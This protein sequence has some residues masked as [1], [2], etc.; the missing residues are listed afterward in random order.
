MKETKSEH[1]LAMREFDFQIR[2]NR[3]LIYI[4]THEESRVMDA[5]KKICLRSDHKNWELFSWDISGGLCSENKTKTLPANANILDQTEILNWF[6]NEDPKQENGFQILIL[7]DFGKLIGSDGNPGQIEYQIIRELR[8]QSHINITK[9]K[10]IVILGT[11]LFLPPELEKLTTVIDWPLPEKIDIKEKIEELIEHAKTYDELKSKFKLEY[12]EAELDEIITAFQGLTLIEVELLCSYMILTEPKFDSSLISSKKRDIVR[13]SGLID[14]VEVENG[15]DS[16]GGLYELKNWL[17]KRKNAFTKEAKEY[18]LPDNPKG[19]LLIG[20]QGSG[21]SLS[22]QAIAK[23]WNLPLLKLDM[24]KIFS[25]IV[26]SSEENIRS[27]IKIAESISPCLIMV[28]EIEKALAGSGSSNN[29][30]GGTAARVFASLLNWM[31]EKKKPV[32]VVATGNDVSQLP[33]ELLR[34]GRFD[35]IFFVDLPNNEEREEIFNIHLSKRNRKPNKFNIKSLVKVSE[36]FTGAEIES[37][38]VSAMYEAF[39]DNKREI[40]SSDILNA[41][42]DMVPLS[43]TMAEQ[44]EKLRKWAETRARNASICKK[45][46]YNISISKNNIENSEDDEL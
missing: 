22:S 41:L 44:I 36:N 12:S 9:H 31:Q 2:S 35:E 24:G 15:M 19:V 46:N 30:D 40:N 17:M 43:V 28:D 23:F 33:P 8:N 4:C 21:K 25:G 11:T 38:I 3:P 45:K 29:T 1:L 32:Y 20:T 27:A 42:E 37:A 14:W 39:S 5:L 7:K 16:V 18:G 10:C 26:G 6:R 13:K 34:K